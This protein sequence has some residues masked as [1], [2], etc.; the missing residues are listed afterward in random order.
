MSEQSDQRFIE[1]FS[2]WLS[3]S[4]SA[5]STIPAAFQVVRAADSGGMWALSIS[6]V[7]NAAMPA[8][9]AYAAGQ[10]IDSVTQGIALG[11][12]WAGF[13]LSLPWLILEFGLITISAVIGQVR[14]LAEHIL[15]TR[16]KHYIAMRV[17]QKADEL[18]VQFFEDAAF[19]DQLQNARR[20]S[21]FRAMALVNGV[22][23]VIQQ[24][25]SLMSFLV[26]VVAF[27]PWI[28]VILFG[29]SIPAFIAQSFYSRLFFRLLTRSAPEFRQIRY[30]EEL[31]TTDKSIKEVR[32]FGLGTPIIQ[33]HDDTFSQYYNEDVR[34]ARK[35]SFLSMWWGFV[36]TASFYVAYAW[37]IWLTISGAITLGGLTFY[38]AILRQ[39]QN[40]F[41]T[42]FNSINWLFE[43]GLF[44]TQLVDFF[45]LK[46]IMPQTSDAKPMPE[47]MRE[48]IVF[49]DVSFRYPE[50]EEW[51]LRHIN[52][53]I[54][55]G[56]TLALVG[57]NGAGK[58][59]LVKLLTRL[60]DPTEGSITIDG[61]DI[62]DMD[63]ADLQRHIGVIFQDFVRYQMSLND[64][65][66]FG[67]VA[68]IND[69][70]RIEQA[71]DQGGAA[72]IATTL[73]HGYDTTLGRQ[74]QQGRELSGGQWQKIALSRAFMRDGGILIL[75]EPTSALDAQYE[76][77]VFQRFRELTQ[78][79]TAI[80]IS[81]RFSTVRMADRIAVISGGELVELGTHAELMAND[82]DYAR[83]FEMQASGYR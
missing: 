12:I 8:A 37:V 23:A 44:M 39:S 78:G 25:I 5:L 26:I 77:E 56:E 19:Y 72:E 55:A 3:Q 34:L 60:Y 47:P 29:A 45:N 46:P 9:Q 27:Q 21:E 36:S 7:V 75:D 33:R 57:I 50:R 52:L 79:R 17:M 66:G 49:H 70:T 28:A 74:F 62:R 82:G 64:N 54:K 63:M 2:Q 6:T 22:F 53:H 13:E 71:A 16:L 83:L 41:Q 42:L 1:R 14:V 24:S 30:L 58:T 15:N 69:R 18:D 67:N 48:G 38:M 20:Q 10:I 61:I 76:Y 51:T 59:T 4:K 81:H 35:R 31:M 68:R 40:T 73:S 11:N 65:I 80:L 43:N 32:L